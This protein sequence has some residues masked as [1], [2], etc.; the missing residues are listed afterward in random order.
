MDES[1]SISPLS[2]DNLHQV[3]AVEVEAHSHP[4]SSSV[5][6]S[7]L[8]RPSSRVLGLFRQQSLLGFAIISCVVDESELIN[9]AI[10]PK[11]QGRGL[12]RHLLEQAMDQ[13]P[14]TIRGMFLEVR[15]SN[16]SAIGLYE[17]LGFIETGVR[18]NYY[19]ADSGREDAVLMA[20]DFF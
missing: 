2:V 1:L 10:D 12:G 15:Q 7:L 11:F 3:V 13:L 17:S 19:P 4:C 6:E 18:K 16:Q 14:D 20:R 8:S 5:L 9:I